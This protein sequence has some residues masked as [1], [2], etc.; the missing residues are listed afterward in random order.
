[1]N[2]DAQF[3]ETMRLKGLS[4][5]SAV[6]VRLQAEAVERFRFDISGNDLLSFLISPRRYEAGAESHLA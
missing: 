5:R 4:V 6:G 3:V 2:E 1:M